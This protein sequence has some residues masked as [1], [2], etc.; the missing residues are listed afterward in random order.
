MGI[1][2]RLRTTQFHLGIACW[3][4]SDDNK[5]LTHDPGPLYSVVKTFFFPPF[6]NSRSACHCTVGELDIPE[7]TQE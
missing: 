6:L 1:R 7:E 2:I 5:N 4:H 3:N